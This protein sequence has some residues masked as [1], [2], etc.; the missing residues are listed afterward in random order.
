VAIV[1][2]S[3]QHVAA[4]T[5]EYRPSDGALRPALAVSG[6]LRSGPRT[7]NV[8]PLPWGEHDVIEPKCGTKGESPAPLNVSHASPHGAISTVTRWPPGGVGVSVS[9][10][11]V[12]G[13]T[14]A[15]VVKLVVVLALVA[16]AAAAYSV[17]TGK[18]ANCAPVSPNSPGQKTAPRCPP[19][20]SAPSG[21]GSYHLLPTD[22]TDT[23]YAYDMIYLDAGVTLQ[24]KQNDQLTLVANALIQIDGDLLMPDA[25]TNEWNGTD[26]S[27][28]IT[29]VSGGTIV[30]HGVVGAG[31]GYAAQAAYGQSDVEPT[32]K[33]V[34]AQGGAG[35]PGGTVALT[36][37]SGI[38]I[39]GMVQGQQGGNGGSATA[40]SDATGLFGGCATAV[41]GQAGWGGDVVLCC[42]ENVIVTGSIAGGDSGLNGRADATAANGADGYAEGGPGNAAGDVYVNGLSGTPITLIGPGE[43]RGGNGS[44]VAAP[45]DAA[46]GA[47]AAGGPGPSGGLSGSWAGG[48]GTAKGGVGGTGGTVIFTN[49]QC[50][51]N[52]PANVV[53]GVGGTG[54]AAKALGG[55]GGPGG[56]KN[57]GN[58]TATGGD[59]GQDGATPIAPVCTVQG[60]PIGNKGGDANAQPG[61]GSNYT[62]WWLSGGSSGS[63]TAR[64]GSGKTGPATPVV[65]PSVGPTGKTGGAAPPTATSKGMP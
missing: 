59:R 61:N 9:V 51:P 17:I 38:T 44:A 35:Q 21:S 52:T 4:L 28:G 31:S 37:A 27:P 56:G 34:R 3:G 55:V 50:D 6:H 48:N 20:Q 7:R 23:T 8:L 16:L 13:T 19:P 5:L 47:D 18:K 53:A 64:G 26:P 36:A 43:L 58:A 1:L 54:G 22:P 42:A 24:L 63:S 60:T 15:W 40:T 46:G 25:S 33:Y 12:M 49:A 30:V 32:G 62:G 45:T 65:Q 14:L 29:L 11:L 2:G 41:G 57:G 39:A 10:P